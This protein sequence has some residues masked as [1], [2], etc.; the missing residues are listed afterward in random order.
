MADQLAFDGDGLAPFDPK[1]TQVAAC[2]D[3]S[4]QFT[5]LIAARRNGGGG[6]VFADG[7]S[8]TVGFASAQTTSGMS[9]SLP[10]PATIAIPAGWAGLGSSSDSVSPTS[11]PATVT[12]AAKATG[13]SG[14]LAFTYTGRNSSNGAVTGVSTV[15]VT[16][17]TKACNAD[18]TAPTL[19]LPA[20]VTTE[21]T[22][23][24]GAVVSFPY[25]AT[26]AD[27][28]SPTVTCTPAAG[29]TFKLGT[30]PVS[31]SAT[32]AAGNTATGSF[33]VLVRDTTAP[34]VGAMSNIAM[35]ATGSGTTV[36]WT[37]PV[38]TDAVSGSPAVA[39]VPASGTSFAVGSTT[40]TC[41]ATD[42]AGNTG[43]SIFTVAISDT[44]KPSIV[45]PAEF[46]VD[47]TAA[48]GA[49]VTYAASASD[50][51]DGPIAVTC[52]PASGSVLPLGD[53]TVQCSASDARANTASASFIV[54]VV[55]RI[56]P[57]VTVPAPITAEATGP[58]GAVVTFASSAADA[59]SGALA[60]S[61]VPASGSTFQLGVTDVVC[62][63]EDAAGNTG[64]G[65][66]SVTVVDTTIP[67]LTLPSPMTV[68]ATGPDGAVVSFTATAD[69][70][71]SGALTAVC[72]PASGEALDLGPHQVTCVAVDA[73]GNKATGVFSVYVVDTTG[74]AITAPE[75]VTVEATGPSGA[76]AEYD[77]TADD[78]VS[79]AAEVVCSPASN[80]HFVLGTTEVS[81]TAVDAEG[82]KSH[83]TF[84]VV[85]QD[86][87]DPSVTVPAGVTAEATGPA[88][89]AV[90]F[91]ATASD[92]VSGALTPS[93]VPP[94]GSVFPLGKSTVS[95]T[96][97]D[98]AGNDGSASFEVTVRDTTAPRLSVPADITVEATG[99]EG[100][101]VAFVPTADDAVDQS[102]TPVCTPASESMFA[103][104]STL[105]SCKATDDS[106]NS[107]TGTFRVIVEDTT[108][109]IVEVPADIT[110]E[111]SGP[112]G[113]TVGYT[114]TAT[115]IVDQDVVAECA[116][117]AGSTFPIAT[118]TVGCSATDDEGNTGKGSFTI[119]VEDTTAPSLTVPADLTG[120]ATGPEGRVV[121]FSA[122][123]TDIVAGEVTPVC[124]PASGSTFALGETLVT[125]AATDGHSNSTS[126]AFRVTVVDTTAPTLSLPAPITREATG[127]SGAAVSF[128][129]SATDIVDGAVGVTC[130]P[131][132][133]STF[134]LGTTTVACQATDAAGNTRH[135]SFTVKV[136][137]TTAPVITWVGGPTAGASYVFGQVPAVG[138]C[139]A[140]DTVSGLVACQVAGYGS[141]VGAHTLTANAVDGAG[142]TATA[143]RS[144]S[145]LAWR[146]SGFFQ[147]VDMNGV[148]NTV[149]NGA[150][151]PLKFEVFS[152]AMELTT[153]TAIKTFT[154]KEVSCQT[155]ATV[156]DDIEVTTTGGTSL[157]YDSTA[158]QFIQNWQTPKK[159]GACYTVTMTTLDGSFISAN[160]KLK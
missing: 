28:A 88:G 82:N 12:L 42:A 80:T 92:I 16:W 14:T 130:A 56:A 62:T 66:F 109:P 69:D 94:T 97:V 112:S 36:S 29:S 87:T 39:C 137:D 115:D 110:R 79:G 114:V 9:A 156:T 154:Q 77:V 140:T 146:L 63:A 20:S 81:C 136:Q 65:S 55:D 60:T 116:P 111:A 44:T 118:T 128:E 64:T 10:N 40:V 142:N 78:L 1:A 135:G 131:V 19:N 85:V 23:S 125:C 126:K 133:G 3:G 157:R 145:V 106:G 76:T 117:P 149:K 100:R 158:G 104:G 147:P 53:T 139:T 155:G 144:Y 57:A 120:E 6:N 107:S 33:N 21:A 47:A 141:T 108:A 51:V 17:T 91:S 32:D 148:L 30:T 93:C 113:A 151:V 134:A 11:I 159:P 138:T 98:G 124:T 129:A 105:V 150:T 2:T 54:H 122:T 15:P 71:V 41:S 49:T 86:T 123:A 95:C 50:S 38:A 35:E 31:C 61:C 83:A 52:T 26:D 72:D 4:V 90:E 18:T 143:E 103:L 27:P 96:A 75:K 43:S 101:T 152:G 7:S 22:S 102:V 37:N 160:F 25:S 70:T 46:T 132:S 13:G 59:V 68:E 73:A 89:A 48:S 127:P 5:V 58:T 84:G 34:A 8:V 121:G 74:P 99:P 24:A 67:V 153:T 119:T 45:V